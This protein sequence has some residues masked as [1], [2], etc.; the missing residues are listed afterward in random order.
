MNETNG[1]MKKHE[2]CYWIHK[3][4]ESERGSIEYHQ[5]QAER[6]THDYGPKQG[7]DLTECERESA[8]QYAQ[9]KIEE[10]RKKM[11]ALEAAAN[12]LVG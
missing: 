9:P 8:K 1:S 6:T 2:V 4:I 12:A 10:S 11:E 3:M 7:Q 5:K